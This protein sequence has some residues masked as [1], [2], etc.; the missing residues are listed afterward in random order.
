MRH[1]TR[2]PR[3]PGTY[4][5]RNYAKCVAYNETRKKTKIL[6]NRL[7]KY[8]F[9]YSVARSHER[10]MEFDL[11]LDQY[12]SLIADKRCHYCGEET[13]KTGTGLDRKNS[14]LGYSEENCVPCCRRCN[15]IRGKD[16]IS[17][18]EMFEVIKLLR[19]LRTK[20]NAGGDFEEH[21]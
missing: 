15:E 10:G 16:N 20:A 14:F 19:K 4:Y 13:P 3:T 21:F 17:Y 8:R 5:D 18:S 1:H 9:V 7:P 6:N 12:A 11:T 2:K